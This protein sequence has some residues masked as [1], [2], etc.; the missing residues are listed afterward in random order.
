MLRLRQ[1]TLHR[2]DLAGFTLIELMVVIVILG[3]LVAIAIP[4]Y[5]TQIRK[6]RRTEAKTA[7]V[8][9]AGREERYYNTNNN[10]YTNN[11]SA[12]G[13]TGTVATFVV[14]SGYYSV[15]IAAPVPAA[16][17]PPTYQIT[18]IPATADQLKDAACLYFSIDNLGRQLAATNTA[19]TGAVA[20]SPCWQ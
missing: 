13:Y 19:G 8:D 20:Q 15:T 17:A 11:P 12:L 18:A 7:L 9:L 6:S 16:G 5:T 14:G 1:E 2:S 3:V 10:Q 4:T